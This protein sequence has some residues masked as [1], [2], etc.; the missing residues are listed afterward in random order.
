MSKENLSL[1]DFVVKDHLKQIYILE[2]NNREVLLFIRTVEV[3][4][5]K[6][7][8]TKNNMI[9]TQEAEVSHQ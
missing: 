1:K 6:V 2:I 9:L 4:Q 8:P 5:L 7:L 3:F